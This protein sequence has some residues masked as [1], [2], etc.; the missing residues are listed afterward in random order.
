MS[1]ATD[2]ERAR[3]WRL[4]QEGKSVAEVAELLGRSRRSIER[5]TAQGRAF[6]SAH[7]SDGSPGVDVAAGDIPE[8]HDGVPSDG[9]PV[10]SEG[11]S[12]NA[13]SELAEALE[14]DPDEAAAAIAP[15]RSAP[16]VA[17][18][19]INGAVEDD[20]PPPPSMP[21]PTPEALVTWAGEIRRLV[22]GLV[23]MGWKLELTDIELDRLGSLTKEERDALLP[24]A[25]PVCRRAGPWM[26]EHEDAS[27]WMFAA[28]WGSGMLKSINQ[29]RALREAQ[30]VRYLADVN[31]DDED[32]YSDDDEPAERR[33]E[34][35]PAPASPRPSTPAA[36]KHHEFHANPRSNK[37]WRRLDATGPDLLY[38]GAASGEVVPSDSGLREVL[39]GAR[40]PA[41]D[42]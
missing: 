37:P 39:E 25:P 17:P 31:D 20:E 42:R 41:A 21:D 3:A 40:R 33:P 30:E 2:D 7:P 4:R 1:W 29:L 9:W 18:D 23:V 28:V 13:V 12:T 11:F 16:P 10:P 24:I 22:V 38:R 14:L 26:N 36:R 19:R 8:T 15:S 32:E 6:A 35:R 5:W 34:P 27:L